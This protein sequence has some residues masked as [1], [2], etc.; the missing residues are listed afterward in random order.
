M[1]LGEHIHVTRATCAYAHLSILRHDDGLAASTSCIDAERYALIGALFL[2]HALTSLCEH[3][4]EDAFIPLKPL[5][6]LYH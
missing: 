2:R 6:C 3:A 1:Q 5:F 4:G